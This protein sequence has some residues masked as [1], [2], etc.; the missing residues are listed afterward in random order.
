VGYL[1]EIFEVGFQ[2]TA[3]MPFMGIIGMFGVGI[4]FILGN[5]MWMYF[6]ARD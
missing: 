3:F 6:Y 4:F 2:V 1:S 5:V